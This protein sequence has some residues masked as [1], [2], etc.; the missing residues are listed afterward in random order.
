MINKI[1][2]IYNGGYKCLLADERHFLP[3][4]IFQLKSYLN[5][6]EIN[7]NIY[8][9]SQDFCF[10]KKNLPLVKYFF[11][12]NYVKNLVFWQNGNLDYQVLEIIKNRL[13]S[14][15]GDEMV[16]GLSILSFEDILPTLYTLKA[17]KE[18]NKKYVNILGGP[19]MNFLNQE[20]I[21]DQS[22]IIDY[23]VKGDGEYALFEILKNDADKNHLV[24]ISNLVFYKGSDL[25]NNPA[26]YI[27]FSDMFLPDYGKINEQQEVYY[28]FSRGCAGKCAFCT[29][30]DRLQFKG[31]DKIKKELDCLFNKNSPQRIYF[32][33]SSA[34]NNMDLLIE[35][36]NFLSSK[37]NDFE[38]ILWVDF[39]NFPAKLINVLK[40]YAKEKE[41]TLKFGLESG[42]E[43]VRRYLNKPYYSNEQVK[44]IIKELKFDKNKIN[45]HLNIIISTPY[46]TSHDLFKTIKLIN[47]LKEYIVS[48]GLTVFHLTTGSPIYENPARYKIRLKERS[49]NKYNFYY[50]YDELEGFSADAVSAR[51]E[52]YFTLMTNFL[53]KIGLKW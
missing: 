35:I 9:L 50:D 14:Q 30:K 36:L 23:I 47:N 32:V 39:Y 42:A 10:D 52:K 12:D 38:I 46:E 5:Y 3:M 43:Q 25:I 26:E 49:F 13:K 40:N 37:K 2:L 1:A 17:L 53:N 45:I 16:F 33:D 20:L 21:N 7:C 27:R 44:Q 31:I 11:V 34:N 51:N 48:I 8:Y 41:V 15:I 4:G 28:N 18:L 6:K 29:F 24:D 19:Y 22:E